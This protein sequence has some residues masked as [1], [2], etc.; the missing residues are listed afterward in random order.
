[1]EVAVKA[2][3]VQCINT[4]AIDNERTLLELLL[5][6]PHKNLL[7]VY[8]IVTDAP[9]GSVRLV[10]AYCAG[11]SLDSYLS[12]I[13]ELGE[14]LHDCHCCTLLC[15]FSRSRSYSRSSLHVIA[16]CPMLRLQILPLATAV[17]ILQ[18]CVAGLHH[19]H[20][21]GIIHRDFRAAN[22][23]VAGKDPLHVVVADFGLSHQLRV[24]AD[25]AAA[26]APAAGAGKSVAT[27]LK[28]DA[29][30]FPI[31]W[32]APEVLAGNLKDGV[33]ATPASDVYMLGGLMFEVLTCGLTPFYWLNPT[34]MSQRRRQAAGMRFRP[35]GTLSDV[36][37]LGSLSTLDA[38]AVDGVEIEW[39]VGSGG[40]VYGGGVPSLLE[41]MGHCLDSDPSK[42]PLLSAVQS[43][44]QALMSL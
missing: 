44:L 19:L 10:M 28:G 18:Q 40:G 4:L 6:H 1:M 3:G 42:R 13:R 5:R 17:N 11:G 7:V 8:G 24:H 15:F 36:C 39:R 29:A 25:A 2:N 31:A 41:L 43:R 34:L 30:L 12:N 16:C 27:V 38:A 21:L 20:S 26:L 23:L 14:V 32:V 35:P 9:D 37:G 33:L 22:V